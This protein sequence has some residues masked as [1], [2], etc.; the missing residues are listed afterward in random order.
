MTHPF[1]FF[2][3][4]NSG[5]LQGNLIYIVFRKKKRRKLKSTKKHFNKL[6]LPAGHHMHSTFWALFLNPT[7]ILMLLWSPFWLPYK[8]IPGL[9]KPILTLVPYI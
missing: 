1:P 4:T 8:S 2:P 9:V 3:L 6:T 7:N 5:N